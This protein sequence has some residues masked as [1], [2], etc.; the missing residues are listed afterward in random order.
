MGQAHCPAR[1]YWTGENPGGLLFRVSSIDGDSKNAFSMQQ[2][3]VTDMMKSVPSEAR[4][5]L[6]GLKEPAG[7]T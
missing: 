2:K 4:S 7:A 3:F 6:A 5:R 1:A